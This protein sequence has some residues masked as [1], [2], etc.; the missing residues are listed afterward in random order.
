MYMITS[1]LDFHQSLFTFCPI[2]WDPPFCDQGSTFLQ[3]FR[4]PGTSLGF[5]VWTSVRFH[6][7]S[8]YDKIEVNTESFFHEWNNLPKLWMFERLEPSQKQKSSTNLRQLIHQLGM[9]PWAIFTARAGATWQQEHEPRFLRVNNQ[10][11]LENCPQS[12]WN[13]C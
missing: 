7:F 4:I 11:F 13:P 8:E 10:F 9:L 6:L 12:V 2:W 3:A 1:L 5:Q